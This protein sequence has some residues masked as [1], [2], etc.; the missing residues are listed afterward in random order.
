M[1]QIPLATRS[2]RSLTYPLDGYQKV[3]QKGSKEEN[4]EGNGLS[5][6]GKPENEFKV[7]ATSYK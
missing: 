4:F 2:K 5:P 3:H 6:I 1:E 7:S